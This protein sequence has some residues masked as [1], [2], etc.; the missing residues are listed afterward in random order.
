M[1]LLEKTIF[2]KKNEEIKGLKEKILEVAGKSEYNY[3]KNKELENYITDL[4][5]R[6]ISLEDDKLKLQIK[7]SEINGAKGGLT[8][9]IHKLN[10]TIE[11]ER[12]KAENSLKIANN[13]ILELEQK[14]KDLGTDKY[15]VKKLKPATNKQK[16]TM[17]IKSG[18]LQGKIINK[19]KEND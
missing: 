3:N 11:E 19:I 13:T 17:G 16:Q 10:R 15:L 12:N 9:Q 7:M 6:I 18:V 4:E 1:E 8:K 14:I 2:K 5:N